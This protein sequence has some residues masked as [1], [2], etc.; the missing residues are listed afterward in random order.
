MSETPLTADAN[1]RRIADM[2]ERMRETSPA[3]A[4]VAVAL[5][6]LMAPHVSTGR[7]VVWGIVVAIA[8]VGMVLAL[9]DWAATRDE[10]PSE[11]WERCHLRAALITGAAWGAG[12]WLLFPAGSMDQKALIMVFFAGISASGLMSWHGEVR[13]L[14]AYTWCTLGPFILRLLLTGE[15]TLQVV[16]VMFVVYGSLLS[17]SGRRLYELTRDSLRLQAEAERREAALAESEL[18]YRT[19]FER[20]HDP[21]WT[22]AGG[23]AVMAN[24]AAARCLGFDSPAP[25]LGTTPSDFSPPVQ[26]DGTP[27]LEAERI[28]GARAMA[29]GAH[30][31]E[32]RHRRQDGTEFPVEVTLT[33]I[34]HDGEPALFCLWRDI[35]DQKATEAQLVAARE[36][37][38]SAS[39]EK[40]RFL[41]TMSHEIRTPMNA[42]IGI[43]ELLSA[44]DLAPVHAEQARTV[45][46]AGQALLGLLDDILDF[47]KIEAGELELEQAPFP[48]AELVREIHSVFAQE[49]VRKGLL[50]EVSID[51]RPVS[52][53]DAAGA[54]GDDALVVRGDHARVRQV[55]VN[56]VSNAMKFTAAG[57]VE[58]ALETAPD[59]AAP[60]HLACRFAVRDTGIGMDPAQQ[61]RIFEP[62]RQADSSTTRRFGGTGL[63]L[64]IV[65]QL[66]HAMGSEIAVV[67]RPGV[68]T[69]FSVSLSLP[70]GTA[71][72][73]APDEAAAQSPEATAAALARHRVLVAE[74][75]ATN[76]VVIRA[77]L[78]KLGVAHEVVENGQVAVERAS[79]G[80]FSLVLMD[81]QM[82]QL[83]GY[84]ATRA[85][86]AAGVEGPGGGRLPVVALTANVS[87][88]D[89]DACTAAGMD[90]FLTKPV[91][92]RRLADVL[93]RWAPG[94]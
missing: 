90:D 42:V 22:V 43:S 59:P 35:T 89:R 5:T 39:R 2:F 70:L 81:C 20:A 13:S 69:T 6:G 12:G 11:V 75:V 38:L 46:R 55:L 80:G 65:R 67:S 63:G 7:L 74:D 41:A 50:W 18:R 34:V 30:R 9:R 37:A 93:G 79:A 48:L 19:I 78:G 87:T 92:L 72:L 53:A 58:L 28:H 61:R 32:W 73:P 51:G 84:D 1:R 71:G 26:P 49:A 8:A 57:T 68:G 36:E 60:G 25:L 14:Q 16:G 27:S 29:E 40:S 15:P 56:L 33:R 52:G 76:R 17:R 44:S 45:H 23:R 3:R 94:P 31:F 91:T 62:F 21:M 10:R 66:V 77:L 82:P 47:S 88:E 64:S 86:R 85:L 4:V 24:A 83:D 54:E